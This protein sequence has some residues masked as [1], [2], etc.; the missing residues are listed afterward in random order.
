MFWA[1]K[2]YMLSLE[3]WLY[4]TDVCIFIIAS[5]TSSD[6]DSDSEVLAST[7][8]AMRMLTNLQAAKLANLHAA[9]LT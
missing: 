3:T 8:T 1:A 4:S 7:T 9:L 6:S 2:R 5:Q